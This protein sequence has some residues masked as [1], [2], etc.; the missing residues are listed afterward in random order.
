MLT[1]WVKIG[2]LAATVSIG[3]GLAAVV[4]SEWQDYKRTQQEVVETRVENARLEA[5]VEASRRVSDE[6][7]RLVR[8]HLSLVGETNRRMLEATE[9]AASAAIDAAQLAAWTST[10]EGRRAA[11][12]RSAERTDEIYSRME[13]LSDFSTIPGYGPADH[14]AD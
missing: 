9:R 3:I 13:E 14:P 4:H 11:A 10:P 5:E 12:E 8:E 7:D 1:T 2:L 6:K